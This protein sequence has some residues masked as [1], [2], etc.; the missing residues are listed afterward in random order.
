METLTLED[1]GFCKGNQTEPI[2]G[3]NLIINYLPAAVNE[4]ALM[5]M[6]PLSTS[7]NSILSLHRYDLGNMEISHM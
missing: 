7:L 1:E 4:N 3:K 6:S 5:V 2:H